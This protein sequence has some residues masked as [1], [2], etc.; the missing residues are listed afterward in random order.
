MTSSYGGTGEERQ[1]DAWTRKLFFTRACETQQDRKE[2]GA[3]Y[4]G[5]YVTQVVAQRVNSES[6]VGGRGSLIESA[7]SNNGLVGVG[8]A[9]RSQSAARL[10]GVGEAARDG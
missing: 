1:D 6:L 8:E 10:V 7:V 3:G 9:A 2:E 4:C 5:K